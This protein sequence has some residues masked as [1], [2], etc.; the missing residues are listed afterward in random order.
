M[1]ASNLDC[2]L[3]REIGDASAVLASLKYCFEAQAVTVKL[4]CQCLQQSLVVLIRTNP[5]SASGS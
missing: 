1:V 3:Y 4:D 2:N 5:P